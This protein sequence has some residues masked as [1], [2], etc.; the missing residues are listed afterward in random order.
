MSLPAASPFLFLCLCRY[1]CQQGG[2]HPGS[3]RRRVHRQRDGL[4]RRQRFPGHRGES[5]WRKDSSRD[6][7]LVR[8]HHWIPGSV[9]EAHRVCPITGRVLVKFSVR[10][11]S[12]S[13]DLENYNTTVEPEQASECKMLWKEQTVE[14]NGAI[15]FV[16]KCTFLSKLRSAGK[17]LLVLT[18]RHRSPP[19]H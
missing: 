8:T 16:G 19:H 18:A 7:R 13:R 11:A 4:Q 2:R 14:N 6:S 3:V 5:S 10:L 15:L 9:L 17:A 1:V 12:W